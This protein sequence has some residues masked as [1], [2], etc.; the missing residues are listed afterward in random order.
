MVPVVGSIPLCGA[1]AGQ[2]VA[3]LFPP[4][5]PLALTRATRKLAIASTKTDSQASR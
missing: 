1:G 4:A 2:P 5:V 3:G